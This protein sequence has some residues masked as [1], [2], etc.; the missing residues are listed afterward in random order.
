MYTKHGH[1]IP[2]TPVEGEQRNP[3]VDC[4]GPGHCGECSIEAVFALSPTMDEIRA[5]VKKEPKMEVIGLDAANERQ[6]KARMIVM[7]YINERREKTDNIPPLT[8]E[9]IYV[10]WFAKVLQNWK[11][12]LST[13]VADGMYYELTFSGD[14]TETYLDAYKKFDNVSI[15]D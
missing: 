10:V 13:N 14:K 5:E 7:T 3:V 9:D 1:Q 8:I 4:G 2:R 15:P 11:A 6:L 12:L